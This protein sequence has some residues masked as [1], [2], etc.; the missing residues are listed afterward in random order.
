MIVGERKGMRIGDMRHRVTLRKPVETLDASRQ[1]IVTWEDELTN[2][3]AKYEQ[4]SGG[5]IIRGKQVE[6]GVTALFV[7]NYRADYTAQKQIVFQGVNY[8]IVRVDHQ[9]GVKRFMDVFCKAAPV[10]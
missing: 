3:P 1:R 5:E 10:G 8:G 9:D 4:V 6:A 7:V 2:Q